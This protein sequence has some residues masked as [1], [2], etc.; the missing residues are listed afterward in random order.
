M[1]QPQLGTVIAADVGSVHTRVLFFDLVEGQFRL[2]GR[3]QALTTAAPR[4]YDVGV[5]LRRALETIKEQTGRSFL[6]REGDFTLGDEFQNTFVATAS[7]GRPMRAVL[8]GLM[9]EISLESGK[10]ALASTVVEVRDT[11]SLLDGRDLATR[12]NAILA[13]QPDVILITGG[14]D[15][16]ANQPMLELID[17]VRL[18]VELTADAPPTVLFAGNRAL[19][20]IVSEQIGMRTPRLY[21]TE[22]VRP[23]LDEES[24]ESLRLE[25]SLLYGEHRANTTPGFGSLQQMSAAG[26][27]PT[28]ESYATIMRYLAASKGA[29]AKK[30]G[31]LLVD[32]GSSTAIICA[33]FGSDLGVT[34]RPDLGLGH[35]AVTSLE[36]LGARS[37]L[38]WL[39]F[40]ATESDLYDY[41]W[42]KTLRPASVPETARDLEI[43]Y[44]F[45][46]EI[47]RETLVTARPGWRS[48]PRGELLPPMR[49]IVGVGSILA[50]PFN[51]GI[52][53][54]LM[55]DALQ[56]VD[57]TDLRLDP[58]GI[59]AT[60]GAL[61]LFE[62]LLPVQVLD[63]GGL[64][65]LAT[66]I[67]PKGKPTKNARMDV[68]MIYDNGQQYR[69][70]VT[71][72]NLRVVAL[73]IG[74]KAR[75]EIKLSRGL[76]L[77]GRRSYAVTVDGS[78][79]GV[80]FDMR[81]RPFFP[82]RDVR[83]RA[84]VLPMWYAAVQGSEG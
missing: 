71:S 81:G 47:V 31:A 78:A 53:A 32:V 15:G 49:P 1:V 26:V 33:A 70:Q 11:I 18:A 45:A 73:P 66:A 56:P 75:L 38:R 82:P 64:L 68:S 19:A 80:I 25:L 2:V 41:A 9:P 30:E 35:S 36:R 52:S 37:I 44:A 61:A 34:V 21:I 42:N 40:D 23:D 59:L 62:P 27:L 69:F 6:T 74:Q 24:F 77:Y 20:M 55:L 17:A 46:R 43:E 83:R 14:T 51:P 22:N 10:R 63:N 57:V 12:V 58:Y 76:T 13:A 16:G 5:G 54:L 3:A 4:G 84:E 29:A 72:G 67:S 48:A 50:Q 60:L 65:S 39:S 28:V 8:V 79:A 7:G